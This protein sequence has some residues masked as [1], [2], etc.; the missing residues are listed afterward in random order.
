MYNYGVRGR[1]GFDVDYE[2]QGACR[3]CN[4]TRKNELQ[5]IVAN[6]EVAY[7]QAA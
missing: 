7:A 3:E 4:F 5:I 6:D 2:A 1:L